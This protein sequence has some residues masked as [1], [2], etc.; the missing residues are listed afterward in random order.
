MAHRIKLLAACAI[1]LS[2]AACMEATAP[3]Q[4]ASL[5]SAFN[6]TLLGFSNTNNTFG[7]VDSAFV[8]R[9]GHG[10]GGPGAGPAGGMCGGG[11]GGL[12]LG[13]FGDFGRGHFG[14]LSSDCVFQAASGRVVCPAETRNG[15]T[16]N[17]SAAYTTAS[18]AVQQAFDSLT[19][20]T[21][22]TKI[23]VAGTVT[24]RDSSVTTVSHNSDRTVSG[25]AAGST[26]RTINGTSAGR[27]STTGT[28]STGSFTSVRVMGD[29][30][31]NV[32]IPVSSSATAPA[33]PTSGTV[34][35]SMSVTLT[36]TGQT[37]TTSTRREV[38][39]YN[40]TATATVVITRDGVTQNCTLPL[41]HGRLTCTN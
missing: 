18:G 1:A 4:D 9:G 11:L 13:G 33:Y 28:N 24:R 29:T 20:N 15:L 25:L 6:S 40:G 34:V 37:P 5:Y 26:Q 35:R 16:I 3:L 12:F 17:K 22:N 21:I 36:Y 38:V 39:T 2:S 19:T 10:R 27:E 8:P 14:G 41:P 32:R 7:G 30:I 31:N 23:A